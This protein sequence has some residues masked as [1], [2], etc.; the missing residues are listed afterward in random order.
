MSA[1]ESARKQV[2]LCLRLTVLQK[3]FPVPLNLESAPEYPLVTNHQKM[4][5]LPV[6][7]HQATAPS[8]G[9]K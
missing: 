9:G 6:G 8:R 2:K 4:A 3:Y 5:L 7:G 1:F